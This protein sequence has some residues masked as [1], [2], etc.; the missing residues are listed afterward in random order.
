LRE[1]QAA[2]QWAPAWSKY[3]DMDV[4]EDEAVA[5]ARLFRKDEITVPICPRAGRALPTD[6]ENELPS[7]LKKNIV[8][9]STYLMKEVLKAFDCEC[10]GG[11]DHWVT[12]AKHRDRRTTTNLRTGAMGCPNVFCFVDLGWSLA[13]S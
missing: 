6:S 5:E 13:C 11:Q 12:T 9:R 7:E 4:I 10:V 1:F 8:M 2:S 3:A